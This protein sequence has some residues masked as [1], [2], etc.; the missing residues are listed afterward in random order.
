[1]P[2]TVGLVIFMGLEIGGIINMLQLLKFR[3]NILVY[4]VLGVYI[5]TFIWMNMAHAYLSGQL[6]SHQTRFIKSLNVTLAKDV[7]PNGL[8]LLN[9]IKG[10]STVELVDEI[11]LHLK[12]FYHRPDIRVE[13]LD[14]KNLPNEKY[15]I[16]GTP[17]ITEGYSQQLIEKSI[18]NYK[19]NR[20][21]VQR[22][23]YLVLTTPI[24]MFKQGAKKAYQFLFYKKPL[25]A[26]GIYTFYICHDYWYTYDAGK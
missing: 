6:S 3:W 19:E 12:L 16:V 25:T 22:D 11:G 14:L 17:Q 8:V 9:F 18:G 15:K 4:V 10:D 26:D 2:A 13:Y 5:I 20:S 23:E 7:P 21:L 1:M 24:N